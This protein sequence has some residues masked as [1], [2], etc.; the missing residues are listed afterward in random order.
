V[1]RYA[2]LAA[3]SPTSFTGN[4]RGALETV[5]EALRA[6]GDESSASV[7]EKL[8]ETDD[9]TAATALLLSLDPPS[10]MK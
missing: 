2:I 8:I 7:I 5:V 9:L 6:L 10:K 3:A 1:E 4:W